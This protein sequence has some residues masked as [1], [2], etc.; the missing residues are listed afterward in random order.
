MRLETYKMATSILLKFQTLKC[1]ISRTIWR[2]EVSDGSL[3]CI[4][5]ALSFERNLFFDPTCPLKLIF[6]SY[7]LIKV[8]NWELK[9]R[10]S[11]T[12]K[13]LPLRIGQKWCKFPNIFLPLSHSIGIRKLILTFH[14]TVFACQN[15]WSC[16]FWKYTFKLHFCFGLVKEIW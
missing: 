9:T 14:P 1:D 11:K 10:W 4:F 6:N 7:I 13:F 12:G 2:I 16:H 15:L 8:S 3:F 5:H